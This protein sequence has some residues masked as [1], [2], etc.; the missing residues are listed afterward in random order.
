MAFTLLQSTLFSKP[1]LFSHRRS[2]AFYI[3]L[4]FFATNSAFPSDKFRQ[5]MASVLELGG[6]KIAKA[7]NMRDQHPLGILKNAIYDYFDGNHPNK[8]D[9]FDDLY[10]IVS[11]IVN[12]DDVF[13]PTDHVSR[14]Y[15]DTCYVDSETVSRCHTSAHQAELL[16]GGHTHFLVTGVVYRKDS[17]DS[18]HYPV[19]HQMEGVR[20]FTLADW[21]ASDTDATSYAMEDLKKCLEGD[22]FTENNLYEV[23]RGIAEDLVEEVKLIDNFTKKGMTSHCYRIAYRSMEC[24]L[25]DEEIND[26][27]ETILCTLMYVFEFANKVEETEGD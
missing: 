21:E 12:F 9:K 13:V 8:F 2:F 23:I 17:I 4:S 25:T 1:S 27:Q 18:T 24:S 22:S 11:T 19:F 20:V 14:S 15:N 10:P 26:L 6:V 3:Q 7:G 16:R 5:P